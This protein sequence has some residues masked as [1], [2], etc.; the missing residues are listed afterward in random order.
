MSIIFAERYLN[1]SECEP[2]SKLIL[3]IEAELRIY[4]SVI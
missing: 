4:A 1:S 3:L 2:I